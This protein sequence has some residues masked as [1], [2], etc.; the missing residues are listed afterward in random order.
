M[1]KTEEVLTSI[2]NMMC[3]AC[4]EDNLDIPCELHPDCNA[5][6]FSNNDAFKQFVNS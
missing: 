4:D 1:P 5:C 2:R 6:I 3:T